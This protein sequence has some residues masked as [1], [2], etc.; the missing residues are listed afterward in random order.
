ME[1]RKGKIQ[2]PSCKSNGIRCFTPKYVMDLNKDH[3]QRVFDDVDKLIGV[4]FEEFGRLIANHGWNK[5]YCMS[6]ARRFDKKYNK[7][8]KEH[9][10]FLKLKQNTK[11]ERHSS[12]K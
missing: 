2:C 3:K 12:H 11:G 10:T 7:L 5:G 4:F 6:L 8:K 1:K 9:L